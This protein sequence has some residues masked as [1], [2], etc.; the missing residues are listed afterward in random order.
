M[1][2]IFIWSVLT[3]YGGSYIFPVLNGLFLPVMRE[4]IYFLV[5][6]DYFFLLC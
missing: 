6:I 4:V 1:S 2:I 3:R 5:I